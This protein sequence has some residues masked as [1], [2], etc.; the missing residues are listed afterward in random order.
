[1]AAQVLD[2]RDA[3][4]VPLTAAPR[5]AAWRV[6]L[7]WWNLGVG[8]DDHLV[9]SRRGWWVRRTDAVPHARVQSVRLAQGPVQRR[10]GLAALHLDSPPGPVHVTFAHGETSVVRR[11]A[12]EATHRAREARHHSDVTTQPLPETTH[13]NAPNDPGSTSSASEEARPS[14]WR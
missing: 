11:M 5:R 14:A 12:E 1:V 2:G 4:A 10:L 13:Q 9:V 3:A 6:P 7:T 8:I